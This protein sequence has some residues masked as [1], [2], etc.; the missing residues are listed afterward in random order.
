MIDDWGGHP[1]IVV[2]VFI[3]VCAYLDFIMQL[4]YGP[5]RLPLTSFSILRIAQLSVDSSV[6]KFGYNLGV[7]WKPCLVFL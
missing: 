3:V 4:Q 6:L 7:E 2:H 1:L 5:F